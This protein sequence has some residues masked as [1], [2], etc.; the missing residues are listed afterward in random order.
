MRPS[1]NKCAECD[2]NQI[3]SK[4]YQGFINDGTPPAIHIPEINGEVQIMVRSF[5]NVE[6]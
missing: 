6:V 3:C 5:I 2:F 4:Q 1:N